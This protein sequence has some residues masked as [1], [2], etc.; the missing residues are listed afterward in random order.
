MSLQ[1][2]FLPNIKKIIGV[3][4]GHDKRKVKGESDGQKLRLKH[5]SDKLKK[6][7]CVL[8]VDYFLQFSNFLP[9][10]LRQLTVCE[11]QWDL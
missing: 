4:A 6:K 2:L 3:V 7:H 1:V 8:F 9:S 11:K 10:S 5:T